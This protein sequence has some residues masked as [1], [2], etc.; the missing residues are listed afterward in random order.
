MVYIMNLLFFSFSFF[1]FYSN[2]QEFKPQY[3][4]SIKNNNK[5][6]LQVVGIVSGLPPFNT[7]S[8][9]HLNLILHHVEDT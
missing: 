5:K 9:S 7:Q 6:N 2:D 8:V 3:T 1:F 4:T